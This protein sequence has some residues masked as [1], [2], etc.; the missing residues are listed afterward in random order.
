MVSKQSP[1][2]PK[3][4]SSGDSVGSRMLLLTNQIRRFFTDSSLVAEKAFEK[5]VE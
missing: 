1:E 2:N 5:L 3:M 4:N